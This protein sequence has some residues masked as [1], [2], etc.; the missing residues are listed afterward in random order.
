MIRLENVSFAYAAADRAGLRDVSLH[1]P[2]GCCLL[3]SG[4]SG[5]GKT[6]LTRLVNGLIPSFYAGAL[7]G[8]VLVRGRSL[9]DWSSD[10]LSAVVGSVFQ[11]P[12]SQFFNPDT[13]SEI[14]FGCETQGL[15]RRTIR[16]RVR[17]AASL[18]GITPLLGKSVFALSG[19]ERQLVA[20]A[21]A[22]ASGAELFVLDEPSANLDAEGTERL[23][24]A[25][26]RLKTLGKTIL[27]AE[28]RLHYLT[29]IAD[30]VVHLEQGRIAEQ[31][32]MPRFLGFSRGERRARGL[33]A[34]D[35]A[36]L[37][38]PDA[39]PAPDS[40]GNACEI[41]GLCLAP[42]RRGELLRSVSFDLVPGRVLALVGRNGRGK[43]TLARCL[44]G[45]LRERAG[46]VRL[47]DVPLSARK[48][49]GRFYL[50]MQEPVC[51]LFTGS[52]ESELRLG[53]SAALAPDLPGRV[54]GMLGLDH[55]LDRHPMSLSGGEKQ[56][57][58]IAAAVVQG[59]DVLI[60]DEPTSGLDYA[61]MRR[62]RDVVDLL[63]E[64]GKPVCVITHDYEFMTSVCD[65]AIELD[66][67]RHCADYPMDQAHGE[68]LRRAFGLSARPGAEE[69]PRQ[70]P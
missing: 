21:S 4:G 31:W 38:L 3:L 17:R 43:T 28:H 35:L 10:E 12:R 39:P 57:L 42:P 26:S 27:I 70:E 44:C 19:G 34:R 18:L 7:S 30:T 67:A 59:A 37:P 54:I 62:V 25:L 58:A 29:S 51:Q 24:Q 66:A 46:S 68:R 47:R 36:G 14:A 13:T 6:T 52:V 53:R 49:L 23:G 45:L 5:S 11:N 2:Q 1:V 64:M 50:V 22:Y 8:R 33:R 40:A 63:R 48:R 60:L 55:L 20:I 56:R 32:S 41:R 69:R 9:S 15:D 16:E 61:S 65:R